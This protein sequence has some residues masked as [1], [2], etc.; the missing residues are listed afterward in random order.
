MTWNMP[1]SRLRCAARTR[2]EERARPSSCSRSLLSSRLPLDPSCE[3]Q[4]SQQITLKNTGLTDDVT[5]LF[6][7]RGSLHINVSNIHM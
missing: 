5:R 4:Q 3:Q 2:E 1:V 7:I 6:V